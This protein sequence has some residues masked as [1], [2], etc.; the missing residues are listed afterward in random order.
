MV[1]EVVELHAEDVELQVR[2]DDFRALENIASRPG[3]KK[4]EKPRPYH[5]H[6]T[7]QNRAAH[8]TNC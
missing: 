8:Y 1:E 7:H 3:R 4:L 6:Q 2:L 5:S